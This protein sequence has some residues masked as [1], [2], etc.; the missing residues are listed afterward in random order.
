MS[1]RF[2]VLVRR[3]ALPRLSVHGLR[4]TYATIALGS[5]LPTKV[6]SERLGHASPQITDVIY[7]HVMPGMDADAATLVG[8]RI[9]DGLGDPQTAAQK[10]EVTNP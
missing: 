2:T 1:R 8:A 10:E 7:A 5:G 6:V 4:H 9:L 3:V